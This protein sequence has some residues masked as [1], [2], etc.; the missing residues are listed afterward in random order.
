MEWGNKGKV[1]NKKWVIYLIIVIDNWSL[2]KFFGELGVIIS[3]VFKSYFIW[4]RK[5][6]G[7]LY[8]NF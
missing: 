6:L 2:I 3:Y 7:Y 5:D 4:G 8:I 1:D